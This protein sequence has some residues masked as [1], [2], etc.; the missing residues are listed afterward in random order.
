MLRAFTKL[1]RKTGTA[2]STNLFNFTVISGRSQCTMSGEPLTKKVHQEEDSSKIGTHNGTFHCDDALACFLL[3]QLPQYRN[4]EIVRTRN[5]ELLATCDV[6]VDVGGVYDPSKNRYDHHQRTFNETMNS[7]DSSK[8]WTTKLSSAGL[9]YFHFGRDIIAEVLNWNS[10][11]KKNL[12]KIYD[13]VY[14]NFIE[15]VDAIDNGIHTHDGEPRYRISTN[16]SSRVAH[17]NPSWNTPNQDFDAG[18]DKAMK[19]TGEE[20]LERVHFYYNTWMPARNLVLSAVNARIKVDNMGSIMELNQGG[21]P[22]KDH[23]LDI[24]KELGIEGDVKL[25]IYTDQEGSWRVQ[26]VPP[27]L[28]SFECRVYLP[29]KW[30]GL[31]DDKLSEESAIKGCIFVHSSGFIGGNKTR[32]GA[33]EMAMHTLKAHSL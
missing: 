8:K 31:R 21:C 3:K 23:L 22:W 7:L 17:L 1:C 19:L 26:G 15:E 2:K 14:E 11:D 29:E 24:E 9:V 10:D 28:G 6:V 20:F 33:L 25:V 30:R 27:V 16:L 32:E 18:F 4:A 12:E 5:Q 13:K